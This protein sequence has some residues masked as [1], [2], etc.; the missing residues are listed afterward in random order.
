MKDISELLIDMD[1]DYIKHLSMKGKRSKK[2][3]IETLKYR[4]K[5][6]RK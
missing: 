5:E 3:K 2:Y 1:D 4:E 6:Y